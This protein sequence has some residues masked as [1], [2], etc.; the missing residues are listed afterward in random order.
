MRDYGITYLFHDHHGPADNSINWSQFSGVGY[1]TLLIL[2][3]DTVLGDR[4]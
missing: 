3:P 1:G 4:K 2:T